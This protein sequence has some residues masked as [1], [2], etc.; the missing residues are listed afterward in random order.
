LHLVKPKP[1]TP[2]LPPLSGGKI[3][4]LGFGARYKYRY[5]KAILGR[6]YVEKDIEIETEC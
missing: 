3:G 6:L 5:R 4:V 2:I 1:K